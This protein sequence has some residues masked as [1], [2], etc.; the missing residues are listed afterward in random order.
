MHYY[1]LKQV[2]YDGQYSYSDI[3][4]VLVKGEGNDVSIYPNPT[5][6]EV[7]IYT[8]QTTELQVLDVYGRLLKSQNISEGS[9]I[10]N[11]DGIPTG[12]LFFIVGNQRFKVV[13]E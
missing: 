7:T 10:L 13:K 8:T 12:M 11:L 2:D 5:S 1:R 3:K 4:S 9:N 6:S